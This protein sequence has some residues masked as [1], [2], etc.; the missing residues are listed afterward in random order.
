MTTMRY[1]RAGN[2]IRTIANVLHRKRFHLDEMSDY[3]RRD[4]GLADG[5]LA[6]A[7]ARLRRLDLLTLTPRAS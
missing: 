3:M 1:L 5:G 4:I 7:D 6:E 2:A